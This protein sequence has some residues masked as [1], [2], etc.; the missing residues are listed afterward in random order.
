M[1]SKIARVKYGNIVQLS[2][3][4]RPTPP[5][6]ETKVSVPEYKSHAVLKS[7]LVNVSFYKFHHIVSE[8]FTLPMLV[9]R[10]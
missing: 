3:K 9:G 10:K 4:L 8:S 6:I 5:T 2:P 7:K 1:A